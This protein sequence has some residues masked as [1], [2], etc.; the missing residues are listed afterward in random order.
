MDEMMED[1]VDSVI[2]GWADYFSG[3]SQFLKDLERQSGIASISY[4]EYALH[5]LEMCEDVCTHLI[6]VLNSGNVLGDEERIIVEQYK[7]KF[8]KL[9]SLLG[10][11]RVE[12]NE[13][14]ALI[15]RRSPSN[16]S[17]RAQVQH[18][19]HHRGRPRFV[20]SAEQLEYLRS[21]TFT[22]GEIANLLGVSRMTIYRRRVEYDM[23]E[24]PRHIPTDSELEHLVVQTRMQLPYLGEVMVLGRL[25]AM[26]YHVTRWRVRQVIQDTDPI[27]R[28]LRWGSNL[29]VRRPYSVP[30]PNSLWH[31]G[32][33]HDHTYPTP[34]IYPWHTCSGRVMVV[35]LSVCLSV[36]SLNDI[37]LLELE[38]AVTYSTGNKDQKINE[39]FSEAALFKSYGIYSGNIHCSCLTPYNT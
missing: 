32:M 9:G 38:T 35:V 21:H 25:R 20:I 4:T 14:Q 34:H 37:S 1:Q 15:E 11:L 29:H 18:N 31:I 28:A 23:V 13:F 12:W 8:R 17:Y 2:W 24:D 7:E 6:G 27:N 5:R 30:G 36:C 19:E 33:Q 10:S 39:D 22:W 26:G 3:L 16:V